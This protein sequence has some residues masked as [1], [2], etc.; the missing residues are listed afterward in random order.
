M[1]ILLLSDIFPPQIGGSG[2]WLWELHRRL[3]AQVHVVATDAPGAAEFDARSN[4]A[5]ERQ[6]LHFSNWGLFDPRGG[7]QYARA[8]VRLGRTAARVRPDA[9][10]TARCL[11]E[12]LLA[13]LFKAR[14]GIPY[15][16]FAHGEELTLA[17]AA[18]SELRFLTK[19]VLRGAASIIANTEHT[20]ELIVQ[21]FEVP[22][23]KV[24]VLHPGVDA[25]RFTP[26]PPDFRVRQEL[27]WT[28]RRV[29]LTV[30]AL[31]KRKGQDT[32]I[33][34]LPAIRRR[35]P[36]ILYAMI[37]EGWE[38]P[39]LD[40]LVADH[41]V[42]D[43][44]QFRGTPN[45]DEMIRCYQQCDLFAL[46]NRQVGWDIEGFGIVLIEAQACGKAVVAGSSGGTRE[47]VEAGRTG[48]IVNCESPETVADVV[49]TLLEDPDRC[50]SLG[51]RGRQWVLERFDWSVLSRKA[52]QLLVRGNPRNGHHGPSMQNTA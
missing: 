19:R 34:A 44:V 14:R 47:A 28:N 30:G 23:E 39:Y 12:G 35:C 21:T 51:S 38:R 25:G 32:M 29:V 6:P 9:I 31:Q 27:G 18:S 50:V 26:V 4:L 42:A 11:P 37:G 24:L 17:T 45:D 33:R 40:K 43:V 10:H 41:G 49:S 7:L 1:T 2:R 5:I 8:L 13:L 16:C 22:Q 20:R 52:A 36:D 48:E 15:S 46:P 3:N